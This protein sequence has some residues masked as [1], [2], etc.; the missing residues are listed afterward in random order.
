MSLDFTTIPEPADD[1]GPS[2]RRSEAILRDL[3]KVASNRRR[4]LRAVGV[5]AMS[6]GATSLLIG[7]GKRQPQ[8]A[9]TAT[10]P[11]GVNEYTAAN[12]SDA[13]PN[14]YG[15]Q[16]DTHGPYTAGNGYAAACYGGYQMGKHV[17]RLNWHTSPITTA[18]GE[19]ATRN[20][21]R[22]TTA[23]GTFRCSDG[24]TPIL[25][26]TRLTICRARVVN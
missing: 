12:C 26:V 7:G 11:G 4:F 19:G 25:G 20:A 18:C 13:Y 23:D 21:W 1:P 9:L 8:L 24:T 3:P 15:Q 10:G 17:C 22:W 5:A 14:G 6:V 2:D 16:A